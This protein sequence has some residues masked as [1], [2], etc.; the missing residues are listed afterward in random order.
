MGMLSHAAVTRD[1]GAVFVHLHPA[2]TIS[3]GSLS[4][5][6]PDGSGMRGSGRDAPT[7]VVEFP[8]AFPQAGEY[9]IWVP[10]EAGRPRAH[11][12]VPG[13]GPGLSERIAM[14][15]SGGKDSALALHALQQAGAY[16]VETLITTVTD[17]Y[18]RVS[19]HGVRRSL[20]RDQAAAIGIPLVEV[21][22][23]PQSSNEIY[24]RAMGGGVRPCLRGRDPARGFRRHL[25]RGPARVPGAATR[26]RGAGVPLPD[27]EAT[28]GGFSRSLS[29]GTGSRRV[30]V[31]INPAALDV[32][33][34]GRSFDTH[35]LT[36]L[37]DE[38]DPCGENGE[39]HTFV[40]DGPIL[41]RPIP[42]KRGE[43]VERD[44]FVF[45]RP[46]RGRRVR[47]TGNKHRYT[48]KIEGLSRMFQ[49]L[50]PH[51]GPYSR[52][53]ARGRS[54]VRAA[55][56]DPVSRSFGSHE[57]RDVLVQR[58]HGAAHV[59]GAGRRP[60]AGAGTL[61]PGGTPEAAGGPAGA[62]S[63]DLAAAAAERLRHGPRSGACGGLL[64]AGDPAGAAAPGAGRASSRTNSPTSSTGTCSSVQSPPRWRAR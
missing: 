35:F 37:P 29:Y 49:S 20:V 23:P 44:G 10:G 63:G 45:L 31:C 17:A 59:P 39:F 27:L 4:V 51:V 48:R 42:V 52:T 5:L 22:V 11:G 3:M 46:S 40:W 1:D 7:G 16:R 38:V 43:V 15:F 8:F 6:A 9:T 61:R 62:G 64:H 18:D 12:R 24:E 41:P 32:S 58:P 2:G 36:D 28:N 54:A 25:P 57:L 30:A 14:C 56:S 21:V 19:M 50:R 33:F 26:G 53:G 34:A 55:G 13:D 60:R 47:G